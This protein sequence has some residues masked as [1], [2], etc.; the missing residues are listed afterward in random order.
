MRFVLHHPVDPQAVGDVVEDRFGKRIRFLEHH[1]DAAAQLDDVDVGA[2]DI[3][4][5]DCDRPFDARP[6]HDVVHPV[7]RTEERALPAA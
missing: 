1:A 2:V 4:A 3:A 6:R 5:A 7:Q